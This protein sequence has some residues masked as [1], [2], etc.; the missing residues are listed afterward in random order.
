[1]YRLLIIEDEIKTAESIRQGLVEHDFNV[2]VAHDGSEGKELAMQA[3][4][5]LIVTDRILPGL[6]GIDICR[7]LRDKNID[8]PILILTALGT[9]DDKVEGLDAGAD[10]YL[11]KPFEFKELL[12]RVRAL[13]KRGI[14]F[15]GDDRNLKIA[16]LDLG[17]DSKL[18]TRAGKQIDLTA[19]EFALLE[20][21]LRNKGRVVSKTDI[22]ER[23]WG[24]NFDT[25]TNVVEVYVNYLRKKIDRDFEPKLIH[26]YI[27]MGYVMREE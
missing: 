19:K 11:S 13:L 7:A 5:D 17:L 16:D 18:V 2:D 25:G 24:I 3:V 21:L 20:F 23:V 26:T 27:G 10:D 15:N 14:H 1:M 4:Y 6:N 12:A 9:T 8:T 22:A